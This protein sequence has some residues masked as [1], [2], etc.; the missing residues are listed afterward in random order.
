MTLLEEGRQRTLPEHH[1]QSTGQPELD[2]IERRLLAEFGAR[3]GPAA[4]STA[5]RDAVAA[6]DDATV[7]LYVPLLSE[8]AARRRIRQLLAQPQADQTDV[9]ATG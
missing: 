9:A 6:F 1:E 5:F 4:V 8:R 7:R 2:R 3:L